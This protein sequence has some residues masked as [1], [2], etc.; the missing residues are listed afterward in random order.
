[1]PIAHSY[2]IHNLRKFLEKDTSKLI[3]ALLN[4]INSLFKQTWG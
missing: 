3:Q 1:M 2:L 4:P